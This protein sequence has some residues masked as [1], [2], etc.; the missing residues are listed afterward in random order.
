MHN[1]YVYTVY[2]YVVCHGTELSDYI[3]SHSKVS[4]TEITASSLA[5]F[6][7]MSISSLG[8]FKPIDAYPN[9]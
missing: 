9:C 1:Q 3:S 2:Y 7:A 8:Q 4:Q 6:G 5:I